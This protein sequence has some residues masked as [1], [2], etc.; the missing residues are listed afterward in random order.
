MRLRDLIKP[1]RRL[2]RFRAAD[3]GA[4]I[5]L[6]ALFAVIM[7]RYEA[8]AFCTLCVALIALHANR[9]DQAGD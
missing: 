1:G 3:I 7:G 4:A 5:A 6:L 8:A 9:H 2:T